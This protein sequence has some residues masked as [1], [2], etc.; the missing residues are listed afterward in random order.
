M[1]HHSGCS[2][3][4]QPFHHSV[5]TPVLMYALSLYIWLGTEGWTKVSKNT[6]TNIVHTWKSVQS[7]FFWIRRIVHWMDVIWFSYICF[8]S[9]IAEI[10]SA[11]TESSSNLFEFCHYGPHGIKNY[12]KTATI[13]K[14]DIFH[15]PCLYLFTSYY[16][17]HFT[18]FHQHSLPKIENK[19]VCLWWYALLSTNSLP[20]TR[21]VVYSF[22][23]PTSLWFL[24][25][26]FFNFPYALDLHSDM[27]CNL[28]WSNLSTLG[29][30]HWH[31]HRQWQCLLQ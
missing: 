18:I 27:L 22:T 5:V 11:D 30:F 25:A 6:E 10:E 19:R 20:L 9:K 15:C 3:S 13:G 31:L 4:Q 16:L 8:M 21:G 2:M 26:W 14:V 1:L 23:H 28:F 17:F 7:L 24:H 29:S 12:K